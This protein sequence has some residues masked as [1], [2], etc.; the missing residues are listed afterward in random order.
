MRVLKK[1]IRI[2][3]E[4]VSMFLPIRKKEVLFF[5]RG[6]IYSDNPKYVSQCLHEKA[7]QLRQIWVIGKNQKEL[8]IPSYVDI[9]SRDSI[10]LGTYFARSQ[11]TVDTQIGVRSVFKNKRKILT[12]CYKLFG[13]QRKKQY[14]ISLWH[15]TPLKQIGNDSL[16][17]NGT[18]I[19]I[20]ASNY[21]T[22][23]CEYTKNC[24][25]SAFRNKIPV[26]MHGTPRNDILFDQSVD[27]YALK[28]KLHLPQD[29]KIIMFA[30]TYRNDV[31]ASGVSQMDSINFERLFK[32]LQDKFGGDWV[33]VF[34]VHGIVLEKIDTKA[35]A[36]KYGDRI[37]NGN[38][39]DDMTEYL[40]CTDVLITDYSSSMFDFALTKRPCFLLAPDREYYE[41]VERGFYLDFDALPFPKAYTSDELIEQ[42]NELDNEK[43]MKDIENFLVDM[44]NAED[45]HASERIVDDILHFIDTGDKR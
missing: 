27:V 6:G 16:E 1:V 28:A 19:C 38:L 42:I 24:F 25:I 5:S 41:K 32:A 34:R 22:A 11:V 29:K 43:Y 13:R 40:V 33:F 45:G 21:V 20:I 3:I 39:G 36:K 35:F 8:D 2:I 9:I 26:K 7:P 37:I 18:C 31:Q 12:P 15:G 14:N 17:W 10:R 30:P 4:I 23:G 44:G